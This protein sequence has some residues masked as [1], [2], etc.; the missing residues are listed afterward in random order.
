MRKMAQYSLRNLSK[1][2]KKLDEGCSYCGNKQVTCDLHHIN[3]R[4]LDDAD[5]IYNLSYLCPTCHRLTHEGKIPKEALKNLEEYAANNWR[6]L[7]KS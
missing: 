1:I 7:Y 3:G 2:L 4:N 5:N 6:V